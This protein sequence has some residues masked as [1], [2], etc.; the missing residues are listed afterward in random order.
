MIHFLKLFLLSSVLVL[1]ACDEYPQKKTIAAANADDVVGQWASKQCVGDSQ[2]VK[3]S[4]FQIYSI[5]FDQ[6]N[7]TLQVDGYAEAKD[8]VCKA[9]T[10]QYSLK[11]IGTYSLPTLDQIDPNRNRQNYEN[12]RNLVLNVSD[13]TMV[14]WAQTFLDLMQSSSDGGTWT[15]GQV[16]YVK[17]L[18]SFGQFM[19]P[20]KVIN[21]M[22]YKKYSEI[23]KNEN[24][25]IKTEVSQ[26]IQLGM[27]PPILYDG[28]PTSDA[29]SVDKILTFY[30]S[31]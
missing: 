8:G 20:A 30:P 12:T 22:L 13:A 17:D 9:D 26:L 5:N 29:T 10:L 16:K 21:N 6:Q 3:L 2:P 24:G 11:Y 14:P 1:A 27:L 31:P 25:V 18:Y 23:K 15:L 4:D 28:K 7:F 19:F